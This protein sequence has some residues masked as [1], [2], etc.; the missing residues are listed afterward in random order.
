MSEH[1]I[2]SHNKSLLLYHLVC[3]TKYRRKV[4]TPN[5]EK[6]L[7]EVCDGISK[8]YE[9][10]FIEIGT[11]ED[12]VHFLI[13]SVPVLSPQR[14]VQILKSITGKEIFAKHDEIKKMLWGGHFWTSGYYINTVGQF[15]SEEV[16]RNYVEKQGMKYQHLFRQQ[17][18][19]FD[20]SKDT[21]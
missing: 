5:V 1:I 9:I 18:S 21:S 17:L 20:Q 16:I 10:E 2:R 15:A 12:H 8:R 19:L 11:D 7:V 4:F 14:I 3:P 13:Q 6:T